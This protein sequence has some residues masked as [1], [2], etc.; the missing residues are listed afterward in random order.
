MSTKVAPKEDDDLEEIVEEAQRLEDAERERLTQEEKREV[1]RELDIAPEKLE[2]AEAA[3]AVRRAEE[4]KKRRTMMIVAA[5]VIAVA[6]IAAG[7]F[8]WSRH[9]A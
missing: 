7:A 1:L 2:A 5:A 6:G 4:A 8:A 9:T 3:V